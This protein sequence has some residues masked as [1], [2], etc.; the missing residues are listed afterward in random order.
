MTPMNNN[1][2][3]NL[4]TS[5]ASGLVGSILGALVGGW[6]SYKGAMDSAKR[7]IDALYKQELKKRHEDEKD[8]LKLVLRSLL[9][10]A[11]ENKKITENWKVVHSKPQLNNEA[12]N[13]FKGSIDHLP[14]EIQEKLIAVYAEI[15]KYNSLV[16]YDKIKVPY[17]VGSMDASIQTEAQNMQTKLNGLI[18]D[19]T[20]LTK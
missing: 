20:V 7:T 10:E 17:G 3:F 15:K 4:L 19:L 6:I 1:L 18:T 11:Q 9:T 13:I 8:K 14:Q 12:W 5:L 16:D 2:L